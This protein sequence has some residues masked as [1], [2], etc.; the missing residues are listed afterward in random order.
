[1]TVKLAKSCFVVTASLLGLYFF[2]STAPAQSAADEA[3]DIETSLPIVFETDFK[4]QSEAWEFADKGWKFKQVGDN[5]VLSQFI[6]K[7][8]YVPEVRS[9]FHQAIL[10]DVV[11]SD[12][13]VDVRVLSTH[14]D[15]GHR[16]AC[17]FF[18]YQ[19]PTEFYYVHLGKATDPHANQI[20]I[21]NNEDRSKI[22]LTT[23]DGT[24]WD[25]QWHDV[26]IKRDI[27]SGAIEVF[28]DN[29][30][31]PVMTAK[32]KTF[33]WGR[34]GLG[35]FDDTADFD[36]LTLRGQKADPKQSDIEMPPQKSSDE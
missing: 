6:K 8:D 16:D 13:Q 4:K 18:G 33:L 7:S 2:H 11:V 22:S 5:H 34:I 21:V 30:E 1:M 14:E 20:F 17:L 36:D 3:C 10:K 26:R 12:F 35:S 28:F 19:S 15:Y 24:P 29:M 32:D 9:P 25:D 31:K 23:T 27:Q